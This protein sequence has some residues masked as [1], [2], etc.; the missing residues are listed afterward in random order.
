MFKSRSRRIQIWKSSSLPV[1]NSL[2]KNARDKLRHL[3]R[4]DDLIQ[5][6]K[7]VKTEMQLGD[8]SWRIGIADDGANGI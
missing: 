3:G 7:E 4:V 2:D 5:M 8:H 1:L 6:A